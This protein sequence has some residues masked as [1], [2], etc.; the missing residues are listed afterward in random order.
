MTSSIPISMPMNFS[1]TFLNREICNQ[2]TVCENSLLY[3]IQNRP[4]LSLFLYLI[5]LADLQHIFNDIQANFTVFVFNNINIDNKL[6]SKFDKH[7]ALSIVRACVIPTRI[8]S[9]IYIDSPI[10]HYYSIDKTNR[11]TITNISGISYVNNNAIIVQ[12]DLLCNNGIIHVIDNIP[13]NIIVL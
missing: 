12:Q 4:D 5:E 10:S 1:H 6:I 3:I 8:C 13:E 7:T 9:E 11:L 2:Q